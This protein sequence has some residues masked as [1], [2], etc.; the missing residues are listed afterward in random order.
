MHLNRRVYLYAI[1]LYLFFDFRPALTQ[2][3]LSAGDLYLLTLSSDSPE[4]LDII[5]LVQLQEATVIY[6]T[7]N[8]WDGHKLLSS[9]GTLRC[10]VQSS[11]EAGSILSYSGSEDAS[12]T[13]SGN[14]NLSGSGDNILV[15]QV[16]NGDTSYIYGVGWARSSPWIDSAAPTSNN[17]YI[18]PGITAEG[19]S[20]L[21]LGAGDNY[22]YDVQAGTEA[23]IS[24]FR[25]LFTDPAN[26]SR[27]DAASYSSLSE[28]FIIAENSLPVSLGRFAAKYIDEGRIELSWNTESE[29]RNAGFNIYRSIDGNP[30]DYLVGFSEESHLA[31]LG[32]ST[33]GK[34]Y[35]W[36]D[37]PPSQSSLRYLLAD[38]AYD[39]KES[40]HYDRLLSMQSAED[41]SRSILAYPNP[42]NSRVNV[43]TQNNI[44]AV[45]TVSVINL[46]G[47]EVI[48]SEDG[49]IQ[50][51]NGECSI[52]FSGLSSGIYFLRNRIPD[53]EH[54]NMSKL[55]YL[56]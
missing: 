21:S 11:T 28:T 1:I 10:I 18:P 49:R 22:Q 15:Y 5:T 48:S 54:V 55:I 53:S 2:T 45:G 23:G 17:S 20:V 33:S 52:D 25:S 51:R 44:S 3:V 40:R 6:L 42:F 27:N 12:F 19:Q 9:E 34:E 50:Y 16:I 8:A 41:G 26:F 31:G 39:G 24:D 29:L 32:H 4:R 37:D 7:D 43:R 56:P 46:A 14:F 13:L 36:I 38:V 30:F 47:K 35:L